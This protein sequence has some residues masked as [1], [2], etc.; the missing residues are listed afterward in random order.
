MTRRQILSALP[1][2]AAFPGCAPLDPVVIAMD[3]LIA[4]ATADEV[5][6]SN[7]PL[8]VALDATVINDAGE[9]IT[10]WTANPHTPELIS[11]I[12]GMWTNVLSTVN[13]SIAGIVVAIVVAI[14]QFIKSLQGTTP[15]TTM[16]PLSKAQAA[17]IDGWRKK[18]GAGKA[19]LEK[20]PAL[21]KK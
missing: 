17:K 4:A 7:N 10:L 19:K 16:T 18:L 6:Q 9:T 15:S 8:V 14:Q 12:V 11:Q 3:A 20:N 1:V 13:P 5:I 21:K 2:L